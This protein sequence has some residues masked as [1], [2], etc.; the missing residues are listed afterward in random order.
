MDKY[1]AV[2][3]ARDF[4]KSWIFSKV[5]SKNIRISKFMKIRPVTAELFRADDGQKDRQTDR[6]T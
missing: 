2:G 5:F 3:Q 1:C 4:N 6:Q